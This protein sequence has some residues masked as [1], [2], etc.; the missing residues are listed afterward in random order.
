MDHAFP[1]DSTTLQSDLL[2]FKF[3]IKHLECPVSFF[4]R[5]TSSVSSELVVKTYKHVPPL[6]ILLRSSWKTIM[7]YRL[8]EKEDYDKEDDSGNCLPDLSPSIISSLQ[9][10]EFID[11]ITKN[12]LPTIVDGVKQSLS[13][14]TEVTVSGKTS[15]T[16]SSSC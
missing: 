14:H 5:N 16:C 3:F 12:L 8:E 2:R 9:S 7:D 1:V 4:E 6:N 10:P 11:M 13:A 15:N